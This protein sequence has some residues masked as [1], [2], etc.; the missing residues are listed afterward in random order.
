LY[1]QSMPPVSWPARYVACRLAN[2]L[3]SFVNWPVHSCVFVSSPNCNELCQMACRSQ[4]LDRTNKEPQG[5]AHVR[6]PAGFAFHQVANPRHTAPYRG[7]H[8]SRLENNGS[9][10]RQAGQ[11]LGCQ[12]SRQMRLFLIGIIC[13]AWLMLLMF[14]ERN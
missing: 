11:Q 7:R 9:A 13:D 5:L 3:E 12:H 14:N 6:R 4:R 1:N 2:R 8:A 10:G